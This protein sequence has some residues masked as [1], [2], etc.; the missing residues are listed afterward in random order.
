MAEQK[1]TETAPGP[2]P[3]SEPIVCDQLFD[4]RAMGFLWGKRDELDKAQVNMMDA[5]FKGK[6][7]SDLQG[8]FTSKYTLATTSIGKKGYGRVNGS[9]GFVGADGEGD[10]RHSLWKVL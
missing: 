9:L 4:K 6:R 5:M 10:P 2:F 1:K 8:V 7:K 3:L